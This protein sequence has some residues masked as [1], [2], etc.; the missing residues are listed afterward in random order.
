[1]PKVTVRPVKQAPNYKRIAVT[2]AGG[3]ATTALSDQ[4]DAT[5]VRRKANGAPMCR[6]VLARP[7]IP[8]AHDIATVV[9]GARLRQP[10]SRAPKLVTLAMSVPGTGKP[11]NKIAPT[12][13]GPAVRAGSGTSAYTFAAAAG[14]GKMQGPRGPWAEW[15][16][17]LAVRVNDGHKHD[18]A[19]RA[20]VYDLFGDVYCCARPTAALATTPASPVLSTSYPTLSA[21]FSALIEDWQDNSGAPARTELEYEMRLFSSAQYTAQG[22]NPTTSAAVWSSQ[23]LTAP[24]DYTDGATPSSETVDEEPDAFLPNDIYRLYGRARRY[25][26]AA[27]VGDWAYISVDVGVTP[28]PAPALTA[29]IADA[30]QRVALVA[31][32][33]ATTGAASPL[34]S[35]E[36]SADG[37]ATWQPVRGATRV[38]VAFGTPL[39]VLDYEAPRETSVRY[40]ANTEATFVDVQLVSAWGAATAAGTLTATTWNLKVPLDP[41][42]NWLDANVD[43]DPT[44]AQN[45]DAGV[46]RPI[47]R[48]YPVVVSMSIGGADGSMVVTARTAAEWAKLEA[49]RDYAGSLLLESPRGW[50]RYIRI[51][52][53]SWTETGGKGAA[54]RKVACEFLEVG[55]P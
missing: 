45:E 18:D 26:D 22:F 17:Q 29:T 43:A 39:T 12:L 54:R 31:T 5:Y 35:I 49:L 23:G 52:G 7:T 34:V 33:G 40:R 9:P 28:C 30:A 51:I 10:T 15:L 48:K 2:G 11:K 19:N 3:N 38:P 20:Y 53:R 8:A 13:N 25:F 44:F 4:S 42:L 50:S 32:A 41:T 16:G 21:T 46:F 27:Q 6:L 47:G 14:T 37:G 55:A 36:R 24:L 1:M